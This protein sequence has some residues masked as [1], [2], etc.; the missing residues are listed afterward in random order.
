MEGEET[1]EYEFFVEAREE[2]IPSRI[3]LEGVQVLGWSKVFQNWWKI[4]IRLKKSQIEDVARLL[5]KH[6]LR[7]AQ[8]ANYYVR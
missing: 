4:R 5:K 3:D 6:G 8:S 2:K 1:I 7:L